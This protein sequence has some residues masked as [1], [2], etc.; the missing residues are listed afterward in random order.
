MTQQDLARSVQVTRKTINTVENQVYVPSTVLA[1]EIAAV[2]E[3]SVE[4]VFW[5]A[6]K[7]RFT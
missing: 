1:L 5:L 7:E 3:V 4:E 6:E 2:L